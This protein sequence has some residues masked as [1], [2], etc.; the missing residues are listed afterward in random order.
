MTRIID[1]LNDY[2]PSRV[3]CLLCGPLLVSITNTLALIRL[4][5]TNAANIRRQTDRAPVYPDCSALKI[6]GTSLPLVAGILIA[7]LTFLGICISIGWQKPT[8]KHQ[9]AALFFDVIAGP[10][11]LHLLVKSL[12]DAQQ[13]YCSSVHASYRAGPF[14]RSS[15]PVLRHH[16]GAGLDLH[17][18]LRVTRHFER[19]LGTGDFERLTLLLNL[20]TAGNSDWFFSYTTHLAHRAN[21]FTADIFSSA[22]FIAHDTL[23]GGDD[24]ICPGRPSH[25]EATRYPCKHADRAC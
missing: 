15:G 24:R 13:S 19:T 17:R 5:R 1:R 3:P 21:Q 22:F 4:R 7:T 16:N 25:A 8:F 2:R 23:A 10:E 9:L 11:N 6:A 12:A 14:E 18:N 20:N